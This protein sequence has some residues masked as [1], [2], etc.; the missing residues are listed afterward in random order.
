MLE[1][2]ETWLQTFPMWEEGCSLQI[3]HT[4]AEPGSNGLFPLGMEEMERREDVLGNV[5]AYCR[6]RFKL[7]RVVTAQ[8][9]NP[10]NAQW[11]LSL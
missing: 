5:K 2:M 1:K 4:G 9:G 7:F 10:E 8:A 3:D 11:L 6:C